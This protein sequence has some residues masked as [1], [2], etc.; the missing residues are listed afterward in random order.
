MAFGYIKD[1]WNDWKAKREFK[2]KEAEEATMLAVWRAYHE[3]RT[4]N[5]VSTMTGLQFEGFLAGLLS[6]MGYS[7]ITLTPANDQG[8]D[9]P[10]ISPDGVP[11]V[12]QAKRW[13]G[14]AGN[15]SVQELL[16]AMR[17]YG[18][19][20]GIVV[21]NSTFTRSAVQLAGAGSDVTLC[22]KQ[23]LDEH[24]RKFVPTNMP[25][26]NRDKCDEI[27]MELCELSR[28]LAIGRAGQTRRRSNFSDVTFIS[29]LSARAAANGKELTRAEVIEAAKLHVK[30]TDLDAEIAESEAR[31]VSAMSVDME[32]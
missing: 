20:K 6:R 19:S 7:E 21:T 2:R 18:R 23:W 5:D 25:A 15:A 31:I 26:F 12:V 24:I 32:D 16:G 27:I 1:K 29:L 13:K 11:L 9:L 10:C 28:G 14:V 22:D 30:M 4:L 8:G 17:H 3:S